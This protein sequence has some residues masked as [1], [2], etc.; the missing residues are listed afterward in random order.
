MTQRSF[1]N[2]IAGCKAGD[3]NS[4]GKL[5][6]LYKGRCYS[7]FYRLTGDRDLSEDLLSRL[8][9]KVVGKMTSFRGG[10]FD[11]WLFATAS[12]LFKDHLRSRYRSR[13][14]LEAHGQNVLRENDAVPVS[15]QTQLD[16]LAEQMSKL[17]EDTR[18]LIVLR[19]YGQLTFKEI[20]K[21][22]KEPLGTT[23]S[24]LHRGLGRLRTLM[25]PDDAY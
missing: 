20:A 7:Y 14:A 18:E 21:I 6:E 12:N 25:E 24:K 3:R 16:R 19:F 23:L 4:Y 8:F 1:E 17:D 10:N 5:F 13:A 22:R 15:Q 11:S 9:L 2:I